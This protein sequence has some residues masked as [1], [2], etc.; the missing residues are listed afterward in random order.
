MPQE[1]FGPHTAGMR[2]LHPRRAPSLLACMQRYEF[3]GVRETGGG[4]RRIGRIPKLTERPVSAGHNERCGRRDP[5]VDRVHPD[6]LCRTFR[7]GKIVAVLD[8]VGDMG[9]YQALILRRDFYQQPW[10]VSSIWKLCVLARHPMIHAGVNVDMGG[11]AS[12]WRP[13]CTDRNNAGGPFWTLW[14]GQGMLGAC[15]SSHSPRP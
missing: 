7:T 2:N 10:S 15:S 9:G 8:P 3:A 14:A 6:T 12:A 4:G 5:F 13:S 11:A 1:H